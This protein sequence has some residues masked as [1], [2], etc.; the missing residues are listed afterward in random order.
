MRIIDKELL[1]QKN[2]LLENFQEHFY[3]EKIIK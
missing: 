2:F 3:Y 1:T